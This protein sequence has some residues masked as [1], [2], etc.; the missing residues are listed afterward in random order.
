MDI[1]MLKAI[2]NLLDQK[3]EPIRTDINTMKIDIGEMKTEINEMKTE[4][5]EMKT[6]IK[7][8][9]IRLGRVENKTDNNTVI[10]EDM[11]KK[12][13]ILAEVQSSFQEQL[14]RNKDKDGKSL[15]DRL[16]VIELAVKD[17][18]SRVKDVQKDL[19]RVVRATAENW[20]EIIELKSVK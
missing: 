12:I 11:N 4:I 17:T 7:N 15:S 14:G 19:I 13:R 5:N 20:A 6:D 10:L 16:E 2:E 8:L 3:L 1:E 18:S 9:D